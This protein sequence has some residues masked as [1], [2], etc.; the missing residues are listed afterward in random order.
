MAEYG[1]SAEDFRTLGVELAA[2]SV[3]EPARAE[4][5]RM[6]YALPF[7]LLCDARRE[8][9]ES[10]GLYNREEK[11]GVAYA[12][13]F[14]LGPGCHVRW[15]SRDGHYSRTRAHEVLEFLRREVPLPSRPAAE[16]ATAMPQPEK[17]VIVPT[18]GELARCIWPATK[19]ALFPLKKQ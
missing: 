13:T 10:W 5:V 12:A 17:R 3:D 9:V 2:I 8:V 1:E 14:L 18:L 16:P 19:L 11:G 6:R 7:P 4:E 15:V